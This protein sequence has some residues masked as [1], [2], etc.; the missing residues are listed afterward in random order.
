MFLF[1]IKWPVTNENG[2]LISASTDSFNSRFVLR[3]YVLPKTPQTHEREILVYIHL[4]LR[5]VDSRFAISIAAWASAQV[6]DRTAIVS[7][8][9]TQHMDI[10]WHC[11]CWRS[12][13]CTSAKC[14]AIWIHNKRTECAHKHKLPRMQLATGSQCTME[15]KFGHAFCQCVN[16]QQSRL[17]T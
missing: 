7:T 3:F 9:P 5:S 6:S 13:M 11:H 10:Q 2:C 4:F 16:S 15:P 17:D 1:S 8:I 14:I 12:C